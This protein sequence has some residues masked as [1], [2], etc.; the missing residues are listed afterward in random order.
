MKDMER[1]EEGRGKEWRR[2]S[3]EKMRGYNTT[4]GAE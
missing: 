3:V 2:E 1:E 4:K